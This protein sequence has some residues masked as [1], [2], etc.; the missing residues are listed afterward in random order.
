LDHTRDILAVPNQRHFLP[1]GI[2]G[3]F[4]EGFSSGEVM[5]ELHHK[6]IPEIPRC[7]V[8]IFDVVGVVTAA[9]RRRRFI[10][11][12]RQPLPVRFHLFARIDR[13]HWRRNPSRL[14]RV[15]RVSPCAYLPQPKVLAGLNNGG[16]DLLAFF[17]RSPDFQSRCARHSMTQ[18]ADLAAAY[19]DFPHVEEFN[20]RYRTSVELVENLRS[21]GS[22]DLISV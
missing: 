13:R 22:L 16:T 4:L 1:P 6:A 7:E 19:G 14:Q 11:D 8:I 18:S 15:G 3:Y 10:P 2:P 9:Q 21:S 17:M 12:S 20:V 5:V